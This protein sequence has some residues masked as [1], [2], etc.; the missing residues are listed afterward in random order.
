MYQQQARSLRLWQELSEVHL[1]IELTQS[2]LAVE[3]RLHESPAERKIAAFDLDNTLLLGDIGEAVFAS[4]KLRGHARD[5]T[6]DSY[7][8]L[9]N[10]DRPSAYCAAVKAMEGLTVHLL[11]KVT[12]DVL[13]RENEYIE[14]DHSYIPVPRANPVMTLVV[15]HLR[16]TGYRVCV[17]SASNDVSARIA[18]WKLFNIPPFNV[19]GIRQALRD[20]VFTDELTAPIPIG[21]GKVEVYRRFLGE[22]DPI[23]TGGDSML[24]VPMLRMTDPRGF[25]IWVGEEAQSLDI[26]RQQIGAGRTVHFLQRPLPS[27]FNEEGPES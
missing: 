23:I 5:L 22:V 16:A 15:E 19:F 17:I 20:G 25:S 14:L 6:W 10:S 21:G 9:L 3:E 7:R 8:R 4:L 27:Q 24:D 12:L 13:S 1:P 11:Q 2:L 18:A 26:V